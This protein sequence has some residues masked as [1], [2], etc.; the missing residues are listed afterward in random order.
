[1][2]SRLSSNPLQTP[3]SESVCVCVCVFI[4]RDFNIQ[5]STERRAYTTGEPLEL[6]CAIDAQ[7]ILERYFSVS[8]VFSSSPVAMVGP[9]AVPLLAGDYVQREATGQLTVR[10]ESQAVYLLRLQNLRPEDAG[11]YI[12]RVTERER[13]LTGD[14]IDRSKRSRNVQVTVQPLRK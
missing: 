4:D 6:R 8:W 3:H 12:C 13:T 7:N 1:M 9:N 11:K 5:L 2:A 14:F 10:K